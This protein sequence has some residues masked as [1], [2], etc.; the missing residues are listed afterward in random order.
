MLGVVPGIING[1][2]WVDE[3]LR[4]LRAMLDANPSEELRTAIEAEIARL[5][6][7]AESARRR[8]RRWFLWGGRPPQ[9]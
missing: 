2:Q 9:V 3:R 1:R 8:V 6:P 5:R 4:N 7:E